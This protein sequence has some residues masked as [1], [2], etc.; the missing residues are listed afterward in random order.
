MDQVKLQ[1]AIV[2]GSNYIVRCKTCHISIKNKLSVKKKHLESRSHLHLRDA[3]ADLADITVP[4]HLATNDSTISDPSPMEVDED[5]MEVDLET[6]GAGRARLQAEAEEL[7]GRK[8]DEETFELEQPPPMTTPAPPRQNEKDDPNWFPFPNRKTAL[9]AILMTMPRHPLSNAV[10]KMIWWWAGQLGL[11]LPPIDAI[12]KLLAKLHTKVCHNKWI[13]ETYHAGK[14]HQNETIQAPMV[15]VQSSHIFVRD[16][17]RTQDD[18]MLQIERFYSQ[19]GQLFAEGTGLVEDEDTYFFY[20]KLVYNIND[21]TEVVDLRCPTAKRIGG[22]LRCSTR[23]EEEEYTV[24]PLSQSALDEILQPHPLKVRANGHR[25]ILAPVDLFCDDSAGTDSKKWN[26]FYNWEMRLGGLRSSEGFRDFHTHC[27]A[28]SNRAS[29]LE[30]AKAI[31]DSINTKLAMGVWSFDSASME[32]V[33]VT[34]GVVC[35][36]GDNPMHSELCFTIDFRR[37]TRFCRVCTVEGKLNNADQL[38]RF[39]QPGKQRNWKETQAEIVKQLDKACIGNASEV[40]RQQTV[41]GIKCQFT[42]T[43]IEKLLTYAKTHTVEE[44]RAFQQTL[45]SD[46]DLINPLFRLPSFNGH[47][48]LPVEQREL[49]LRV[50]ALNWQG[51]Q[52]PFR[53]KEMV[54]YGGSLVGK[55]FR[56]WIQVAPFAYDG[57]LPESWM[58]AWFCMAD[59]FLLIYVQ[60]IPNLELYLRDL[61][62]AMTAM[63]ASICDIDIAI[64]S[65][66]KD[67]ALVHII[68]DI[69]RFG[70]PRLYA[71]EKFEIINPIVRNQLNHTNRH[72]PSK[73]VFIRFARFQTIRHL[74]GGGY[75]EE[76]ASWVNAGQNVQNL[77]RN[78]TVRSVLGLLSSQDETPKALYTLRVDK[79]PMP[80]QNT[81]THQITTFAP[82]SEQ[83]QYQRWTSAIVTHAIIRVRI[84]DFVGLSDRSFG[85]VLEILEQIVP[86]N[87]KRCSARFLIEEYDLSGEYHRQ[88]PA[89]HGLGSYAVIAGRD[90]QGGINYQHWCSVSCKTGKEDEL[91]LEGRRRTIHH[92]AWIHSNEKRFLMN[93]FY[94]FDRQGEEL[95][96]LEAVLDLDDIAN[97]ANHDDAED[98]VSSVASSATTEYTFVLEDPSQPTASGSGQRHRGRP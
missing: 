48:D 72:S 81:L 63:Y 33:L 50:D 69:R 93:V 89:I 57:F 74:I 51:F 67:H 65:R 53:G 9:C 8:R 22:V 79:E 56:R 3:Q 20:L 42:Q 36:L 46:D 82:S 27:L 90:I 94:A 24:T 28:T 97:P 32:P 98:D 91:V 6:L 47:Q 21:L 4:D 88:C 13:S 68:E 41:T 44:T 38:M 15:V 55:D 59:V 35:I 84:G 26:P 45:G 25:V 96:R 76:N 49:L 85:R 12:T 31:V 60:S 5:V 75:W 73:D 10:L 95:D 61:Q 80:F 2:E 66:R 62:R 77:F 7:D 30:M 43:T 58:R 87:A 16:V 70:P 23:E 37:G 86:K 18:F 11:V 14:W 64:F 52:R 19:D 92:D 39:L 83:Q 40:R 54:Q 34:G 29:A 78:E 1:F 71:S 17:V